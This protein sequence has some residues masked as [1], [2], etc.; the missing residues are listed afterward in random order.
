[1]WT[2]MVL[3]KIMMLCSVVLTRLTAAVNPTK[4]ESGTFPMELKLE[5]R[6]SLK[7]NFTEIEECKLCASI[8]DKAILQ[9]EDISDVKYQIPAT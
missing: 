1:M 6:I 5:L 9:K 4:L 7:K 3:V 8:I 2:L